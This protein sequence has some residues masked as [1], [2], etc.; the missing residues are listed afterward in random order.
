VSINTQQ[1]LL[2][3]LPCDVIIYIARSSLLTAI[4]FYCK[5]T[6]NTSQAS[7]IQVNSHCLMD[8]DQILNVIK[9]ICRVGES[10]LV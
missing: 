5:S 10:Q 2:S 6:S 1:L 8:A 7:G 3:R 4:L 9:V